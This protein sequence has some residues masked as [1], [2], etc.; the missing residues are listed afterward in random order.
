[1]TLEILLFALFALFGA[2]GL[3][4]LARPD[5]TPIVI[6][7]AG[8]MS[9]AMGGLL[10]VIGPELRWLYALSHPLGTLFAFLL[11][12][13]TLAWVG[14]PATRALVIGGCLFGAA[15]SL[16][17]LTISPKL[18]YAM[19]LAVEPPVVISAAVIAWRYRA[20]DGPRFDGRLLAASLLALA[21]AGVAHL[22][23]LHQGGGASLPLL[24][25]W[26][27]ATPPL[28]GVQLMAGAAFMRR[29]V[30]R[31]RDEL[32]RRVQERTCELRASEERWRAVSELGSDLS[33]AYRIDPGGGV[34]VEWVSEAVQAVTGYTQEEMIE[35]A[36]PRV[37][38]PEDRDRVL[39]TLP[40]ATGGECQ[41]SFRAL[42]RDNGVRWLDARMRV[43]RDPDGSVQL[44]G[45][46]R[47][48]TEARE[49][50]EAR[51][52]LELQMLESQ[53]LESLGQ[54]SGGI[55]HDFN[56]LLTV[57]LGN[58]RLALADLP[59]DS[60]VEQR[61]ERILAAAEHGAALTD[62]MVVYA[63]R[64]SH[65]RKPA[66]LSEIAQEM[67]ELLRVSLPPRCEL[68]FEKG[69]DAWSEVDATQIRQVVLS[70][71][72]NAGEALGEAPG[73]ITVRSGVQ[74]AD[75]ACLA[76]GH[77]APDLA[78]GRYAYLEVADDGPGMDAAAQRRAFEP[79]FG[80]RPS[81]RGLGLATVLGIVRG[82]GGLVKLA[83]APGRGSRFRVLL[84]GSGEL[85]LPSAP[86][87]DAAA[88]RSG[89]SARVLLVDDEPGVLEVAA[90]FLEREG[91]DVVT[92]GSGRAGV[93]RF[94]AEPAGFE[95]AVVDLTMPDVSGEQV[96]AEL[97]ALRPD[98]PLVLASGFSPELAAARCL[99]LG[100]ARFVSKP[101]A[102]GDLAQAVRDVLPAR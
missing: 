26:L 58:A 85:L 20:N 22:V 65:V 31:S 8:W 48:V 15:R 73:R 96:A 5:R 94:A 1:V 57:I 54:L 10:V 35:Q 34:R 2:I 55:A 51:H 39:R 88:P 13:G 101:Y 42:C 36:R 12:A 98:L 25:V 52:R 32:E 69:S 33:F 14:R 16:V 91:F 44:L 9:A 6:W 74:D 84:P 49:A 63:G 30:E 19:A 21:G 67:L 77:G 56:N 83:S 92:A 79:F 87:G 78:P 89:R 59:A 11:L 72:S 66:N 100:A 7:I 71:V 43:R 24:A 68:V 102:A 82:H 60:P 27:A 28:F 93:D 50:E 40:L 37:I 97:R 86:P 95:A 23:W 70:L 80:T 29:A 62:Q 61:L 76:D 18:A 64:G 17:E 90:R 75:A 41:L 46:A 99:A 45:A 53:R 3:P 38:H 81:G 4:I 47:D